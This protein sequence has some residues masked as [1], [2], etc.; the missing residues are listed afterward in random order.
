MKE[1]RFRLILII[2][3]IA[4]SIY[5]LYPTYV[6]YQNSKKIES[7]INQKAK[8]LEK[9]KLPKT[10]IEEIL[11]IVED[12]IKQSDPTILENRL[13]R[14]KLGLDLQGGMRVV[15]EVNIGKLLEKLA[16]N[17]DKVFTSLLEESLKESERTEES[18]VDILAKKLQARGVRLSRY[19]GNIRQ[20]D[21]EIIS[22]LKSD[23]D[24][25]VTRAIEI[26]RNR[27]DQYGVSEPTIQRQGARR[28][29]VELPGV[30]KEEEAKQLLQGTALLEFR[31]VKD[32]EFTYQIME[33]IDKKLAAILSGNDSLIAALDTV[34]QK[35]D[36]IKSTDTNAVND[37]TQKQLTEEEFKK[38]HPFFAV[39]LLDPQG[40][41]ADAFVKEDDRNKI[42]RWLSLPEIERE[43]PDNVEFVFSAKSVTTTEDGKKIYM[44]YLVNKQ[45]ELTGGVIT[46]AVATLDP[47][48][49]SPIVN[50]EMNS[51]G[52]IE[53]ARITGANINKRIAIMLD[54]KVFSAPVVRNKITGGRSQIEGM[55]NLDEAKLL[56]IVL[57]AGALP[58]PVD[59]IEERIVGPS[60]GQDSVSAGLN[61]AI[62]GYLAVAL[63]M[64]IYY[65]KAGTI[66]ALVLVLTILFVLGVLAGFKAT[67]T[68]PGIAGIVLTIGMA[69]DANVLIFERMREELATGKTIKASV[70]S[71]FTKAMSAIIDS[72]ITTFFTGIILY[73]FGTGPVQ[74]FALTLM[75][76]IASTLFSALVI[77]RLIFDYLA[78]KGANI[79][80]G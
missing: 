36:T 15:L 14:L 43:I 9:Q 55:E 8:E 53:W 45:P 67:L 2:A 64:I 71:G 22:K 16:N 40:R 4:L 58:A 27:V 47:N 25:A 23:A 24:D 41:S 1:Y 38:Q 46:D 33:R 74:G 7:I 28:V 68:L 26:I 76:G 20:D 12:S 42:L 18:V 39:A 61:S 44:M 10:E 31:L 3:A 34:T 21:A 57:K 69:V 19:F 63:F 79:S 52:A 6:D 5:F 30:A 48:T 66:S 73:Q 62:L 70:D 29:I 56:E 13:K 59:I 32:P 72:N 17:P 78:A 37:T 49:S 35:S 51:E 11:S 50:M 75:I 60:L 77:S 54:G 65:R 80:L